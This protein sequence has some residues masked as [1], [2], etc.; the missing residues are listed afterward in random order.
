MTRKKGWIGS[1]FEDYL[2]GQGTL[3]EARAVAVKRVLAWQRSGR[4]GPADEDSHP[5]R[6]R[7]RTTESDSSH[8]RGMGS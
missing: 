7:S 8:Q 4:V 2:D 6:S 5:T 1:S 3:E